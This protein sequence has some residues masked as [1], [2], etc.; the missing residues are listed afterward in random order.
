M[1]TLDTLAPNSNLAKHARDF[2]DQAND[3]KDTAKNL[4]GD[5]RTEAQ[6]R[7][8]Q[9]RD[10]ASSRLSDARDHANDLLSSARGYAKE[11]PV[12]TFGLGVAAGLVLAAWLRR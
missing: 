10:E 7:L 5:V 8:D 1:S 9:A 4:A 6:A 3:L 11:N 12:T 2:K